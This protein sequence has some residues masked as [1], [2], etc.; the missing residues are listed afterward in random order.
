MSYMKYLEQDIIETYNNNK[1]TLSLQ[2]I[3]D[4]LAQRYC[5]SREAMQYEVYKVLGGKEDNTHM[6]FKD[7][8]VE[9]R[10]KGGR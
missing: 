7:R 4:D 2:L 9:H 10:W 5:M 1:D 8:Y 3:I 6:R